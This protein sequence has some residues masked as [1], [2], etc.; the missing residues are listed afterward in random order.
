MATPITIRIAIDADLDTLVRL[1]QAVQSVHAEFYPDD[2]RA[3]ADADGLKALLGSRL[4]NVAIAEVDGLSVGYVWF[5]EQTRPANPFSPPSRCLFVHHL[6]VLPDARRRGVAGALTAHAEA[7]AE[8]QDID[9][10]ALS[11][12]AANAAAQQFF[13]ARGFAPYRILLRRKLSDGAH[14]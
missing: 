13:A 3:M 6:S 11:H 2:F 8:C 7:Y 14:E 9:E 5:E 12:W 4:A 1:N 10:I